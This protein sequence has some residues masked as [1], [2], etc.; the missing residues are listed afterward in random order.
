MPCDLRVV[1]TDIREYLARWEMC[2]VG[3]FIWIFR[4]EVVATRD[5]LGYG[6]DP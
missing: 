6:H 3:V 4:G 5:D 1:R 2:Y